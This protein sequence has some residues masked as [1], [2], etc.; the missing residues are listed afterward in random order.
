MAQLTRY[1]AA[2][3]IEVVLAPEDDGRF[4]PWALVHLPGETEPQARQ[5]ADP[6]DREAAVDVLVQAY[7]AVIE[8]LGSAREPADAGADADGQ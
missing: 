5:L 3:R 4:T 1:L 8:S 6:V 2:P 7:R